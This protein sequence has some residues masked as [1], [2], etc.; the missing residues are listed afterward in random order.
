MKDDEVFFVLVVV[1]FQFVLILVFVVIEAETT[2][3]ALSCDNA[4]RRPWR[5]RDKL[6]V[7]IS[8]VER[9]FSGSRIVAAMELRMMEAW[10]P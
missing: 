1:E 3:F 4:I 5:D 6:V 7:R 8:V 2:V 10:A 9:I